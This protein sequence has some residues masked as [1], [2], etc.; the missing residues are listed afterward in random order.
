MKVDLRFERDSIERLKAILEDREQ[1]AKVVT[2]ALDEI[3]EDWLSIGRRRFSSGATWT[4]LSAEWALRKAAGGRSPLPL[5]G[6]DLEA[7][8]TRQGAKFAIRRVQGSTVTLGTSDPVANLHQGGT[9]RLPRRPPVS[10]TRADERRWVE[11]IEQHLSGDR[12]GVGL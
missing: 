6:G 8:L 3:A 11:I 2:P 1:R 12:P 9:K 10:L 4:P 5:A 7:S